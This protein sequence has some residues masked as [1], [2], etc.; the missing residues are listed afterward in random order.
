M[1]SRETSHVTMKAVSLQMGGE[2]GGEGGAM[3]GG[4]N[5]PSEMSPMAFDKSPPPLIYPAT[6]HPPLFTPN[7]LGMVHNPSPKKRRERF[8]LLARSVV[9]GCDEAVAVRAAQWCPAARGC[10]GCRMSYDG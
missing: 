8:L 1:H 3:G 10:T 5:G 2:G 4:R 9:A 7:F 6:L